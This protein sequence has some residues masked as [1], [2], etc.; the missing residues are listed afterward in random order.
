PETH[1]RGYERV[2]TWG[3]MIGAALMLTLDVVLA[4]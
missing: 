1:A 2:A 4:A 3:F